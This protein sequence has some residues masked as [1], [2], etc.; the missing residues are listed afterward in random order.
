[1]LDVVEGE[2]NGVNWRDQEESIVK[3]VLEATFLI[4]FMLVLVMMS[5]ERMAMFPKQLPERR[6]Q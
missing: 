1:M 6:R 4:F 2:I 3:M 5:K